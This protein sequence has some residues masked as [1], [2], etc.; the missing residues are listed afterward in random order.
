MPVIELEQTINAPV[1][2]VF[3]LARS[4]ELHARS[5]SQTDEKVVGGVTRGLL[6]LGDRV[7]FRARHFGLWFELTGEIDRFELRSPL[8]PL[9]RLVDGLLLLSYLERFLR[10]RAE[11]IQGVAESEEWRQDLEPISR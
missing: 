9:G 11:V 2:R 7:T 5:A 6:G 10:R 1:G 4:V 3:D 8:G